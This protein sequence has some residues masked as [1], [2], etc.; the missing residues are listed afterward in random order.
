MHQA[1][2]LISEVRSEWAHFC[3]EKRSRLRAESP[4]H[5]C[6]SW[7]TLSW[8]PMVFVAEPP[9]NSSTFPEYLLSF[10]HFR[11]LLNRAGV[12]LC[13]SCATISR[14]SRWGSLYHWKAPLWWRSQ[15][16]LNIILIYLQLLFFH[17]GIYWSILIVR[18]SHRVDEW[19]FEA[20][21][22]ITG[23]RRSKI[24]IEV[25]IHT[26]DQYILVS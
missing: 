20:K 8:R 5:E 14:K 9:H 23:A 17:T 6:G 25:K 21:A 19:E 12:C 15:V 24:G 1:D 10:A 11:I 16:P 2:P 4:R 7:E 13:T 18:I 26:H 22:M 3:K